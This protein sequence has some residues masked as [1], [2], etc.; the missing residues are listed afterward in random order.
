MS[1]LTCDQS[2]GA[3][4][5]KNAGCDYQLL[6]KYHERPSAVLF[7]PFYTPNLATRLPH[8][9][10]A[11]T[12]LEARVQE[13]GAL[14]FSGVVKLG[15]HDYCQVWTL[16]SE[17]ICRKILQ[18]RFRLPQSPCK[19]IGDWCVIRRLLPCAPLASPGHKLNDC[20]TYD[21]LDHAPILLSNISVAI[22]SGECTWLQCEKI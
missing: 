20:V 9:R 3:E 13:Q 7:G 4:C 22:W 10:T 21:R 18:K 16:P 5:D 17:Q 8:V 19:H 14:A 11:R 1:N 2:T 15:T 12:L 6:D